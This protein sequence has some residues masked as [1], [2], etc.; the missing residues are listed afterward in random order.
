MDYYRLLQNPLAN[1]SQEDW[2]TV[3][4]SVMGHN[5]ENIGAEAAY[6]AV[7]FLLFDC[8]EEWMEKRFRILKTSEHASSNPRRR[9]DFCLESLRNVVG[10]VRKRAAACEESPELPRIYR[11][12]TDHLRKL[13]A[14]TVLVSK[15]LRTKRGGDLCKLWGLHAWGDAWYTICPRIDIEGLKTCLPFILASGDGKGIFDYASVLPRYIPLTLQ[16][17]GAPL[18][19]SQIAYTIVSRISPPLINYS[20]TFQDGDGTGPERY[21]HITFASPE[22]IISGKEVQA[23]FLNRLT[24]RERKVLDGKDEGLSI[25]EIA[26]GIGCSQRTVN[27]DWKSIVA[28]LQSVM[29]A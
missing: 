27:N 2:E 18:G 10:E 26:Q 1:I 15:I 14:A 9:S 12:V 29:A 25:E 19:T 28:K 6:E 23:E 4:R 20:V 16:Q 3:M 13:E 8:S 21:P 22:E 5:I 24:D 11:Q 17:Y 7:L